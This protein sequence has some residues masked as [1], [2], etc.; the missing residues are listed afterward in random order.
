VDPRDP[1][2]RIAA[3]YRPTSNDFVTAAAGDVLSFGPSG[4]PGWAAGLEDP[5]AEDQ[6]I[7]AVAV[8]GEGNTFAVGAKQGPT[9]WVRWV[10]KLDPG[11]DLLWEQYSGEEPERTGWAAVTIA[12]DGSIVAAGGV[13]ISDTDSALVVAG[14]AP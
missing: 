8:D 2:T 4:R 9:T 10:V 5:A 7:T 13:A 1:L 12:D 11:G 6:Y 14:Y 3:V